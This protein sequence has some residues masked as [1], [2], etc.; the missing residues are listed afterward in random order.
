MSADKP[1][2]E[3]KIRVEIA[4]GAF[5]SFEGTQ[6]ELD[7]LIAEINRLAE[8]GELF[9]RSQPLDIDNMDEDE[10]LA[11]AEALGIDLTDPEFAVAP[12]PKRTLQ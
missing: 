8:T 1:E 3:P 9:E 5:D 7:G 6:E 11:L 10:M 4:P 12:A 2:D